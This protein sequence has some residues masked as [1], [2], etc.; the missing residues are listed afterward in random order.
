MVRVIPILFI[1]LLSP[2][3]ESKMHVYS[4]SGYE[5][6]ALTSDQKKPLIEKLDEEVIKITQHAG[7]EQPFCGT[8]LDNKKEGFYACVVCGLPL[9]S[10]EHKFNSGTGWPSFYT[11]FSSEHVITRSDE[12]LGVQR[13]EILCARCDSHLGHVFNDGPKPTGH[14]YCLNSVSL[15]FYEDGEEL[16][17]SSKPVDSET[18]YFAAG[19]F[20]GVE[21][22][23]QQGVGV[24]N[25]QSGY[26]QGNE[27]NPTYKEVC[28][29]TSGHAESVKVVFDPKVIS[30]RT[31]VEAF[32]K[33]HDPT[34]VNQQGP[35]IGSQYRS[36]I[37]T[38]S[39]EQEEIAN[40]VVDDL[41]KLKK[42]TSDI[43][44]QIESA[45][46]FFIA[47]DAHQD[48]IQKTGRRCHVTN[49]WK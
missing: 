49:P 2:A 39:N 26:M 22:W 33:L 11:P 40:K 13:T 3:M 38:V 41:S 17:P 47:E 30:Y 15:K 7:T 6:T 34:Q 23:M 27:E 4:R 9:F 1:L 19:C 37:W 8:L 20:W 24:I 5:I 25:V 45:K 48:Y 46:T 43:A 16:P 29:G 12:S 18:A 44:T 21:H 35:D 31:L 42:F 10:S 36:G 28:S 14:R 32:F